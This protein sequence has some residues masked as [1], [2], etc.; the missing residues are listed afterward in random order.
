MP[1]VS[2]CIVSLSCVS[3][4]NDCLRSLEASEPALDR[5]VIVVDNGSRDG[6]ADHLRRFFPAVRLIENNYNAGFTKGT[7][8]AIALS[9]GR[10]ILWLNADTILKPGSVTRLCS[11]LQAHPRAG[12]VGPMVLNPDGSFQPQCRRGM[13]TPGASLSY[14]L[15]L[16]RLWPKQPRFGGYLLSHLPHDRATPVD[17]VSGCCLMARRA[18]WENVGPLDENIFAHGEDLDWCVRAEKAGWEVWYCPESVIVHLR[19]KAGTHARPYRNVIALHQAMRVF[20]SKHLRPGRSRLTNA[21]VSFG[22]YCSLAISIVALLL[23]KLAGGA[24]RAI[25]RFAG[26]RA[27]A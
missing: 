6:T 15:G 1:D 25:G 23:R 11:F 21:A 8:Q 7:N 9:Q 4:L 13:P 10:Y 12:I 14:M 24:R 27:A 20:Y 3:V 19:G 2:I 22:I 18:V 17:A 26:G 16:H 5:E